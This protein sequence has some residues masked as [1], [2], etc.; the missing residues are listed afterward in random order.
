MTDS[1]P[2]QWTNFR[3]IPLEVLRDFVCTRAEDSSIRQVAAEM[4]LG[5]TTLHSFMYAETTPHPRV[6]RKIAL[7]YLDWLQTAPDIDLVRPY[8]AALDVLI[9]GLPE[10]QRAAAVEIVLDGL[11]LGSVSDGESPPRWVELLRVLTRR[12]T[13]GVVIR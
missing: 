1:R 5:R 13:A 10:R 8:A 11:Q 3:D 6:R 7:C 9:N 4:G 12:R 2:A